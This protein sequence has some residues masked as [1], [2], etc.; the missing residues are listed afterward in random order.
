MDFLHE[1]AKIGN[2]VAKVPEYA[3]LFETLGLDYCCQGNKTLL[4]LCNEKNLDVVEILQRLK[5]ISTTDSSVDWDAMSIEEIVK[6]I[7]DKYHVY[8]RQEIPRINQLLDKLNTKHGKRYAY[9]A[10]LQTV[11]EKMKDDL[12]EHM[13]EEETVVF[14]LIIRLSIDEKCTPG[15][16]NNHFG[17][18]EEDHLETGAALE[19]IKRLTNDYT[20]PS[21]ACMTHIVMLDSLKRLERNLHEHIHKENHIL[22][23]RSTKMNRQDVNT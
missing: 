23:P 2:L 20:P 1:N 7:V 11:F 16:I 9:I 12:L 19:K 15:E 22:F 8:A 13:E 6:Y 4:E 14:P 10:E 21:D 18:L 17:S 5:Q 3:N